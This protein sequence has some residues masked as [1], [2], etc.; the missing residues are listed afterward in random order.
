[1]N[2]FEKN[3]ERAVDRDTHKKIKEFYR[4]FPRFHSGK[5]LKSKR[6]ILIVTAVGFFF[7]EYLSEY[8][9]D[10]AEY[11]SD[12]PKCNFNFHLVIFD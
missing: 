10:S 7:S 8:L 11:L 5:S 1:M 4:L 3:A 12:T 6:K 9:S 2:V